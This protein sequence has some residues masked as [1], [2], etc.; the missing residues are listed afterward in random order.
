[1][2]KLTA[3]FITLL[4]FSIAQAMPFQISQKTNNNISLSVLDLNNENTVIASEEMPR[5]RRGTRQNKR[6]RT[7]NVVQVDHNAAKIANAIRTQLKNGK[8]KSSDIYGD[9]TAGEKI[10]NI[11]V[12]CNPSIQKTINY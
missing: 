4:M 2:K 11:L 1:M 6:L 7:E 8:Y 12:D 5:K 9:G 3:A 10:A